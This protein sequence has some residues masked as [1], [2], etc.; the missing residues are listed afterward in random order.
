MALTFKTIQ[1]HYTSLALLCF[2]TAVLLTVIIALYLL[3]FTQQDTANRVLTQYADKLPTVYPE[4]NGSEIEQLIHETWSRQYAY[5]PYTHFIER[6]YNGTYVNINTNGIR[7]GLGP[8]QWPPS[9]DNYVIFIFGGSTTFGYGLPDNN[10]IPSNTYRILT[11]QQDNKKVAVYNFG[12][13]N[14]YSTQE[15][16]LFTRLLQQGITPDVA[17]FID[18]INDFVYADDTPAFTTSFKTMFE[19]DYYTKAALRLL[20]SL[21]LSNTEAPAPM[22]V[23]TEAVIER[24]LRTKK[25]IAALARDHE[26]RPVFVWQPAPTYKYNLTYHLFYTGDWGRIGQTRQGYGLIDK[27]RQQHDLGD[28]FVWCADIQRDATEPL[29]VDMLHYGSNMSVMVATCVVDG[30]TLEKRLKNSFIT[31]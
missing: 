29:Y 23:P 5:A 24:Y 27:V 20:S 16:L 28:D 11:E 2:N 31:S 19:A 18:G 14:Y 9:K 26:V 6:P 30:M 3:L 4:L 17:V 13:S 21:H 8:Q 7:H 15:M 22:N 25:V 10:T 1:K 12:Q